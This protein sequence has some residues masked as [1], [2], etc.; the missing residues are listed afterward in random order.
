[1]KMIVY[2]IAQLLKLDENKA[3]M[4]LSMAFLQA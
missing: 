3:F 4:C 2:F 1:M